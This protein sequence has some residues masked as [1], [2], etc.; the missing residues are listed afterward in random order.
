MTSLIRQFLLFVLLAETGSLFGISYAKSADLAPRLSHEDAWR[1]N[2]V[3]R[4]EALALVQTLNAQILANTSAT[5]SLEA[6]CKA[7]HMADDPHIVATQVKT[8]VKV[9][10]TDQLAR[11]QV[12]NINEVKYRH[13]QL[14]CGTH[15][16]SEADN[17]YVPSRLTAD[18]NRQLETTD[19]PFGRVVKPLSPFRKTFAVKLLWQPLPI[20][21]E[22]QQARDWPVSRSQLLIIPKAI[23]EH[24]AVLY[25]E[26]QLPFA[27]VSE[28]YQ[29]EVLNFTR[30]F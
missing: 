13:V 23:F 1:D 27:E 17:W 26:H 11:L 25:T 29:G 20:G 5:T 3:S 15:V 24:Q 8:N 18:I 28:V 7:H 16:L 9:P 12:T 10:T 14:S 30:Q 19:T 4:L 22:R 6:W 21:W 2:Y